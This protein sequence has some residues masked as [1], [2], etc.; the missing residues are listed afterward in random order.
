ML[1]NLPLEKSWNHLWVKEVRTSEPRE[2]STK[3]R[4]E[5]NNPEFL[6]QLNSSVGQKTDHNYLFF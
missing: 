5:S 1:E 3:I 4:F 2:W 6:K